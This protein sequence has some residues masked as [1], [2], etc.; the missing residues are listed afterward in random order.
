MKQRAKYYIQVLTL[1]GVVLASALAWKQLDWPRPAMDTEVNNVSRDLNAKIKEGDVVLNGM[2]RA[3]NN[4]SRGTRALLLQND[5]RYIDDKVDKLKQRKKE[6]PD[7]H[8][9]QRRIDRYKTDLKE[10][11]RQLK[12][13]RQ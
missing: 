2:I 13:L 4:Y 8:D 9:I 1:A 7:N 10:V 5:R 12:G 11:N 6:E 3:V